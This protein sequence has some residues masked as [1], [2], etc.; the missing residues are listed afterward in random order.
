MPKKFVLMC[1]LGSSFMLLAASSNVN[2]VRKINLDKEAH[3][4]LNKIIKEL[5]AKNTKEA[6]DHINNANS[7]EYG[8]DKGLRVFIYE[9]NGIRVSDSVAPD[10]IGSNLYDEKE[11]YKLVVPLIAEAES[12][13]K[14]NLVFFWSEEKGSPFKKAYV[15]EILAGDGKHYIVGISFKHDLPTFIRKRSS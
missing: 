15:K 3:S 7:K 12:N 13:N 1:L 11:T 6:F 4:I 8:H 9:S 14:A 2:K 10:R 5:K